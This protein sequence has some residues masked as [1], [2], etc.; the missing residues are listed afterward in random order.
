MTRRDRQPFEIRPYR[1]TDAVALRR[2]TIDMDVEAR[3]RLGVDR[4]EDFHAFNRVRYE[5]W[6]TLVVEQEDQ[7]VGFLDMGYSRYRVGGETVLGFY[8]GLAGVRTGYRGTTIFARLAQASIDRALDRGVRLGLSIANTRNPSIPRLLQ[9]RYPRA[10]RGSRIHGRAVLLG[11]AYPITRR[12]EILGATPDDLPEIAALLRRT[13][14]RYLVSTTL[15]PTE[16]ASLPGMRIEDLLLVRRRGRI[17]ACLGL[18]D[19]DAL[20]RVVVCG[21]GRQERWLRTAFLRLQGLTGVAPFPGEGEPLRLLHTVFAA[22]EP[23]QEHVWGALVRHACRRARGRGHHLLVVGLPE[24]SPLLRACR[25][26]LG[27]TNVNITL[28]IGWDAQMDRAL[29]AVPT[30]GIRHEYALV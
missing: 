21:Y 12:Y 14:D 1:E 27:F 26:L 17:V 18:W 9:R 11:P 8:A 2:L 22:A 23:G 19:Q 13:R 16:L 30:P 28:L 5:A 15:E 7:L 24:K 3:V 6:D 10:V 4:G 29:H 25:G 20:R